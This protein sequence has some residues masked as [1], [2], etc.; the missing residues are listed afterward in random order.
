[1]KKIM[2]YLAVAILCAGLGV[3]S[4]F[5]Q[6]KNGGQKMSPEQRA[7]KISNHLI[8]KLGLDAAQAERVKVINLSRLQAV[9]TLRN[10]AEPKADKRAKITSIQQGY[11]ADMKS[12]LSPAQY[13]TFEKMK[14]DRMAK[15]KNKV[16][17]AQIKAD[18]IDE[19]VD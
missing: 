9:E 16:K 14:T 8:K 18:N 11:Q 19:I 10:S 3:V 12:I 15:R 1:M 2:K 13:A 6:A 7:E 4:A 17:S 5:A